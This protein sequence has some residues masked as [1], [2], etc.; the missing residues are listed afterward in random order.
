MSKATWELEA[1]EKIFMNL[2]HGENTLME[3]NGKNLI[4]TTHRIRYEIQS[5]GRAVVK[6]IMLEQLAS[7]ALCEPQIRFY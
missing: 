7:C 1:A 2:L 3:S 6:S 4:L 5:F